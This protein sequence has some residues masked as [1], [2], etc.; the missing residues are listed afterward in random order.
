MVDWH[1]LSYHYLLNDQLGLIIDKC[2][3]FGIVLLQAN[4]YLLQEVDIHGGLQ[5]RI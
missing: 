5:I 3:N 2:G 4:E 1:G